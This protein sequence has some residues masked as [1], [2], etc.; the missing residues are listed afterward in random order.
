MRAADVVFLLPGFFGFERFGTF[1]YFADRVSAA[2]RGHLEAALGRPVPVIPLATGPADSLAHRQEE[3]LSA[4]RQL[5]AR[6]E[7]LER[8]HLLG[9]STGGL[10][11]E[12]LL[13]RSRLNGS[14]WEGWQR[15]LRE[16]IASVATLAAPHYGSTIA[17][18]PISRFLGSVDVLPYLKHPIASLPE[19]RRHPWLDVRFFYAAFPA[20][21]PLARAVFEHAGAD[22]QLLGAAGS[23]KHFLKEFLYQSELMADLVPAKMEALRCGNPREIDVPVTCLVTC[24][25][26]NPTP[27]PDREAR[28]DAL[29]VY[30]HDLTS[31]ARVDAVSPEVRA[32]L[33]RLNAPGA[34]VI[35]SPSERPR[36]THVYDE[37]DN[38]AVVDSA[39]QLLP[40][41]ELGAI[42]YAD[43]A[44]VI[45]HYDRRDP[46]HPDRFILEGT[47]RSGAQFGDDEFFELYRRVAQAIAAATRAPRLPRRA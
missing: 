22:A 11:A 26:A 29:Y 4:M 40:D 18:T 44:D 19:A 10:D 41:A 32:N 14:P 37:R 39:R 35:A 45:G 12:L 36:P 38:D 24:P 43:H 17:M 20:A 9:H 3:F 25:V 21:M 30:L 27:S 23:I 46:L 1:F 34:P 5:A 31:S 6:F 13:C 8:L 7:G 2:L 47:F 42:V 15:T 16:Q 33:Q 28:P